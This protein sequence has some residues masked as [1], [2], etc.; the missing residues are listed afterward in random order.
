MQEPGLLDRIL[1][2]TLGAI[3]QPLWRLWRVM[4]DEDVDFFDPKGMWDPHLLPIVGMGFDPK[5]TVMPDEMFGENFGAQM[6]GSILTDPLSWL[7]SGA[8]A[9]AKMSKA[10]AKNFTGR[11][12][13][14]AAKK[15]AKAKQV[16]FEARKK[17]ALDAGQE[18][19]EE[20]SDTSGRE[21]L[22]RAAARSNED[23]VGAAGGLKVD[24]NAFRDMTATT[25]LGKLKKSLEDV[26]ANDGKLLD[27]DGKQIGEAFKDFELDAARTLLDD[28]GAVGKGMGD[29]AF[30]KMGDNSLAEVLNMHKQ[31][32]MGLG[33][34]LLGDFFG[35][36]VPVNSQF[37][38]KHGDW[39][40]WYFTTNKNFY[41]YTGK[42]ATFLPKL[43]AD[44]IL[45]NL[46][47]VRIA[48]NGTKSLMTDVAAG[49]KSGDV[50]ENVVRVMKGEMDISEF[51]GGAGERDVHLGQLARDLREP[52]AIDVDGT[53][54]S[55]G[56]S[57]LESSVHVDTFLNA[58]E[59]GEEGAYAA[60]KK[61]YNLDE[62]GW[63]QMAAYL[64]IDPKAAKEFQQVSLQDSLVGTLDKIADANADMARPD[65]EWVPK[66][67]PDRRSFAFDSG[68]R[69]RKWH[70]LVF[71]SDLGID[72]GKE[73]QVMLNNWQA[74]ASQH[75]MQAAEDL[76]AA[77][78]QVVKDTGLDADT[79]QELHSAYI[80]LAPL[81]QELDIFF[82]QFVNPYKPV[83]QLLDEY[84]EWFGGRVNGHLETLIG[85]ASDQLG[86][87]GPQLEQFQKLMETIS[88]QRKTIQL[89]SIN[90]MLPLIPG[91]GKLTRSADADGFVSLEKVREV[92]AAE[93]ANMSPQQYAGVLRRLNLSEHQLYHTDGNPVFHFLTSQGAKLDELNEGLFVTSRAVDEGVSPSRLQ[94]S[95][96]V[97][98]E[99]GSL[100]NVPLASLSR[101]GLEA[102]K[103]SLQKARTLL[104]K[105]SIKGDGP[106]K[107]KSKELQELLGS[108]TTD[109]ELLKSRVAILQEEIS[110]DIHSI[111][112]MRADASIMEDYAPRTT[113]QLAEGEQLQPT[114]IRQ[115]QRVGTQKIVDPVTG[116]TT[117]RD[118]SVEDVL[119]MVPSLEDG[120]MKLTRTM[121]LHQSI[122]AKQ[123]MLKKWRDLHGSGPSGAG[124][125]GAGLPPSLVNSLK[126]D[127]EQLRIEMKN[128][129]GGILDTETTQS[130]SKLIDVMDNIRNESLSI[131][132]ENG[133][134]GTSMP[135]AYMHRVMSGK[136]SD[137]I[138][139]ALGSISPD[140]STRLIGTNALNILETRIK[141][142]RAMSIREINEV[143]AAFNGLDNTH[144][145]VKQVVK[146]MEDLREQLT[147]SRKAVKYSADPVAAVVAHISELQKVINER[148]W[149][150]FI[151]SP[152]GHKM[153]I[154]GGKVVRVTRNFHDITQG[155]R[156]ILTQPELVNTGSGMLTVGESLDEVGRM[157]QWIK[158]ETFTGDTNPL[159]KKAVEVQATLK[160]LADKPSMLTTE[161]GVRRVDIALKELTFILSEQKIP[162]EL[163]RKITDLKE[164]LENLQAEG[165][166]AT[167]LAK[168][169]V[170]FQK[171]MD[172]IVTPAA[173]ADIDSL[174]RQVA[175]L[176]TNIA[177]AKQS[178]D[179]EVRATTG[180]GKVVDFFK[181]NEKANAALI[182]ALNNVSGPNQL[183]F[184]LLVPHTF[185]A[186]DRTTQF[187]GARAARQLLE[188]L[189][190]SGELDETGVLMLR[191]AFKYNPKHLS[192]V[193]KIK[194]N[195]LELTSQQASKKRRREEWG[196]VFRE[197]RGTRGT[198]PVDT[199]R[200][201]PIRLEEG[202]TKLKDGKTSRSTD[203]TGGAVYTDSGVD[204]M[205]VDRLVD[206]DEVVGNVVTAGEYVKE[207]MREMNDLIKKAGSDSA[208]VAKIRDSYAPFIEKARAYQVRNFAGQIGEIALSG[209]DE[210]A[211]IRNTHGAMLDKM[212]AED[213]SNFIQK[214]FDVQDVDEAVAAAADPDAFI[215]LIS[216]NVVMGKGMENMEEIGL[217]SF[218]SK[219]RETV[220]KIIDFVLDQLGFKTA[221][222]GRKANRETAEQ[223]NAL[224]RGVLDIDGDTA[225]SYRMTY[226]AKRRVAQYNQDYW[227][228]VFKEAYP[229]LGDDFDYKRAA[230]TGNIDEATDILLA[231]T[232]V[233]NTNILRVTNASRAAT[234]RAN[235]NAQE[236]LSRITEAEDTK[237]WAERPFNQDSIE[238]SELAESLANTLER[239]ANY[240]DSDSE[241]LTAL[242]NAGIGRDTL[243]K[244]RGLDYGMEGRSLEDIVETMPIDERTALHG[245]IATAVGFDS[246]IARLL[247]PSAPGDASG[248]AWA[249]Q[250]IQ[251]DKNSHLILDAS[252]KV[253]VIAIEDDIRNI[254]SVI[255][256]LSEARGAGSG[257]S[258]KYLKH[259]GIRTGDNYR[260]LYTNAMEDIAELKLS[261]DQLLRDAKK[262]GGFSYKQ[263]DKYKALS[264]K[265]TRRE[266]KLRSIW[267][268]ETVKIKEAVQLYKIDV[269]RQ[270]G[271][272][273]TQ[274]VSELKK[275][276]GAL[277]KQ[278]TENDGQG[279]KTLVKLN[280]LSKRNLSLK[281]MD[282]YQKD[283]LVG[284]KESDQLSEEELFALQH[285]LTQ[286][287]NPA[288]RRVE[289]RAVAVKDGPDRM[290]EDATITEKEARWL[291]A[292]VSK[293]AEEVV[294]SAG[295][296]GKVV[297]GMWTAN[298]QEEMAEEVARAELLEALLETKLKQLEELGFYG[299]TTK[300]PTAT[301][302][303]VEYDEAAV[304]KTL[305]LP[306]IDSVE[307]LTGPKSKALLE[308]FG[309]DKKKL[310]FLTEIL[311]EKSTGRFADVPGGGANTQDLVEAAN[312]MLDDMISGSPRAAAEILGDGRFAKTVRTP[313]SIKKQKA[314]IKKLEK[315]LGE[316]DALEAK[317]NK[318]EADLKAA[319]E[320]TKSM[321]EEAS[322]PWSSAL[323][324]WDAL[325]AGEF[326]LM[327]EGKDSF[328]YLTAE[329]NRIDEL[330]VAA[331]KNND[332]SAIK[333]YAKAKAKVARAKKALTKKL[334]KAQGKRKAK[335]M[336]EF[337][338]T[339]KAIKALSALKNQVAQETA[340]GVRANKIRKYNLNPE[341][342]EAEDLNSARIYGDEHDGMVRAQASFSPRDLAAKD[343]AGRAVPIP[344]E[345]NRL[346]ETHLPGLKAKLDNEAVTNNV[347]VNPDLPGA[348]GLQEDLDKIG[349]VPHTQAN[350]AA[351]G[352]TADN[353]LPGEGGIDLQYNN[354]TRQLDQ[355]AWSVHLEQEDGR[356]IEVSGDVFSKMNHSVATFGEGTDLNA[357]T[358]ARV[359]EGRT[360]A[361]YTGNQMSAEMVTENLLNHHI[362]VGP[363]QFNKG[364]QNSLSLE[365]PS[366]QAGMLRAYDS[367]HGVM[368]MLATGLRF[369][370]DFHAANIISSIP[371]AAMEQVG[372]LGM[373]RSMMHTARLLSKDIAT[374]GLDDASTLLHSGSTN[375]RQRKLLASKV[376]SADTIHKLADMGRRRAGGG[377]IK[378]I[379][380]LDEDLLF[381]DQL[382]RGHAYPEMMA[383][384]VDNGA[385]GT[386]LRA[387]QMNILADVGAVKGIR[388]KFLD[389][390]GT[391]GAAR[392]TAAGAQR[393]A[394]SSELFV[395]I[396]M[397]HA[398]LDT[399][400]TMDQAAKSVADAM[401]NY[402]DNTNIEREL[403]KRG[404]FFYTYPRK[405]IPRAIGYM[406][407]NPSKSAALVN[408]ILKPLSNS[409]DMETSEG[410]PELVIGDY[411]VNIARL[412]PHVD[413]IIS[414][415]AMADFLAPGTTDYMRE[416]S[417]EAPFDRPISPA[418]LAGVA[419]WQEFFPNEDPLQVNTT[420][421]E[422]T[423][424]ANWVT[425]LMTTGKFGLGS[426]D[427]QV[428]YS[429][430]ESAARM[431][432]PFRKVR[433]GQEAMQKVKRISFHRGEY[434]RRIKSAMKEGRLDEQEVLQ[435]RVDQMNEE[436]DQIKREN[437]EINKN[438]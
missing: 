416:V 250:L 167:D 141:D 122:M 310:A 107:V 196:A 51:K 84:T 104:K 14:K 178:G 235:E 140:I 175:E 260:Q 132:L 205:R 308:K 136:E 330:L 7:T 303:N 259:L 313:S 288:A 119:N 203:E 218:A 331:R 397:M 182:D 44:P 281:H 26:L 169:L 300:R 230:L 356:V 110:A 13:T 134:I 183:P 124:V 266:E 102:A 57:G 222:G 327:D 325:T 10:L 409:G 364:I 115:L 297:Q 12:M 94:F 79:V 60:F 112:Q 407:R 339:H 19:T 150:R 99:Q 188:K 355:R 16:A 254:E 78:A 253:S 82:K 370:L 87:K 25:N 8:A 252:G 21:A 1:N 238:E 217:G 166:D 193:D 341:L 186:V 92:L 158:G 116:K 247:D 389:A 133:I 69:L 268:K 374:F 201:A 31:R 160:T 329:T 261:R 151:T 334:S 291:D 228:G 402:A 117:T 332:L 233:H 376:L 403:F 296:D 423:A 67:G 321:D 162:S 80:G 197:P 256:V 180:P 337:K 277:V 61:H 414:M 305:N 118:L 208:E 378:G 100:K 88:F 129:V 229:S 114:L 282:E 152:E 177:K 343:S 29:E 58:L 289:R 23:M 221:V 292:V 279:A 324:K 39:M 76:Y 42:A 123:A 437:P 369:P 127:I 335:I 231:A 249:E 156:Q 387:D 27:V 130:G 371:M 306:D 90:D 392:K 194:T 287:H 410:R 59:V 212:G 430:V 272:N 113:K 399:G 251:Q 248:A 111:N 425:R 348:A 368:K 319:E 37:Q 48:W 142:H 143:H 411:R 344:E 206:E 64:G 365:V 72:Q 176:E 383:A 174:T 171:E 393:L 385:L 219:F 234:L 265:I 209:L 236:A 391:R 342:F 422:D 412:N 243:R 147:G 11:N 382:G 75:T 189:Y 83:D 164:G 432:T 438:K 101:D 270:F 375:P 204:D 41:K 139:K 97:Q 263:R 244:L 232:S 195:L 161:A 173:R 34:P 415:G 293:E 295:P 353:I 398:A 200:V 68:E 311:N 318:Y 224:V 38:A 312:R 32:E 125:T 215:R 294:L 153:G 372:P 380:S 386:A 358:S 418:P 157:K 274:N 52:M 242:L 126:E 86:M 336:A 53:M 192:N 214:H 328:G 419:G 257:S 211:H 384:M 239:P 199:G 338:S 185:W 271:I 131:G 326:K 285:K 36:Y 390:G 128:A 264:S 352:P 245:E 170:G 435:R 395:R 9:G 18:F 431:V 66:K 81:Q 105:F 120:G 246:K 361:H 30:A 304:R 405:M 155:Q 366:N 426:R 227:E 275:T 315:Q 148:R 2:P 220:T 223:L 421:L 396:S 298:I 360:G 354:D 24:E 347:K 20:L 349:E 333:K 273:T 307:K 184:N 70:T 283:P 202:G 95:S 187:A 417:G 146:V 138:R 35:M 226:R 357:A 346:A 316:V 93:E 359:R 373:I 400:M 276:M 49:W 137:I 258:E 198:G 427:P 179:I 71:R 309:K 109:P 45:S 345:Y 362:T 351:G 43:V 424:N 190:S 241:Q 46:P 350:A 159:R 5:N 4:K 255:D 149:Y 213:F 394:E 299:P 6:A 262:V 15:A 108:D 154:F 367:V 401:L 207:V 135:L 65:L 379:Q 85:L 168:R 103:T 191:E 40:K 225:M 320:L 56:Q 3:Q 340:A 408:G 406:F 284:L 28:I 428:S 420:W 54:L 73:V 301:Q 404:T 377:E 433:P 22:Y 363:E 181:H 33:I 322:K 323:S 172:E 286:R 314:L 106:V 269:M 62:D 436:I 267:K 55:V 163:R 17:A 165:S 77:V 302:R 63:N 290:L 74:A 317:K 434:M 280:R 216:S 240:F 47:G 429:M 210:G 381:L 50:P 413:A 144:E 145:S 278:L 388:D 121:K 91:L 237:F 98:H 89:E 96:S